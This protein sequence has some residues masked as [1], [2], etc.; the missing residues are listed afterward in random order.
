[1]TEGALLPDPRLNVYRKNLAAEALRGVIEAE[2]YVTGKPRQ[3]G[4]PV[5]PL[6]REPRFDATLDTEVLL[7]E[8]VSVSTRA[9]W[10]WGSP[11]AMG[12]SALHAE[13][14]ADPQHRRAHPIAPL[15]LRSPRARRVPPLSLLSLNALVTVAG[16][17]ASFS[18]YGGYCL[19]AAVLRSA[20]PRRISSLSPSFSA[21][22]IWGGRTS[23]ELIARPGAARLRPGLCRRR[24]IACKRLSSDM[25]HGGGIN[26][27]AATSC[28]GTDMLA[29]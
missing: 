5:L 7:G 11:L 23:I 6:R 26:S 25:H 2:R 17:A 28:S 12:M 29:S 10:A 1:V 8:T 4:V 3:V 21:H 14:R 22:P 9:S 24:A 16:Q 15:H 18:R 19:P 20:R 13:R 27:A